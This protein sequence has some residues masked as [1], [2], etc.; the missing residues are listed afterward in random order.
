MRGVALAPDTGTVFVACKDDDAVYVFASNT[1]LLGAIKVPQP[2]GVLWGT[3]DGRQGLFIGSDSAGAEKTRVTARFWDFESG[4][5][6]QEY[7]VDDGKGHAAGLA[8][9]G[10]ALLVV[11]QELGAI[12]QFDAAS[13]SFVGTLVAGLPRPEAVLVW[14]GAC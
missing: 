2:I 10:G 12:H 13:G 8:R 7:T 14:T 9:H 3:A 4:V 5:V 1:S 11:G 6:T